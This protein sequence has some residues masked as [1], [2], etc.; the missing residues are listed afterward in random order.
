MC[1]YASLNP[2]VGSCLPVDSTGTNLA[3]MSAVRLPAM[4]AYILKLGS[5][6][7]ITIRNREWPDNRLIDYPDLAEYLQYRAGID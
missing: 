5:E 6:V 7:K 1:T 4:R 2:R 3:V